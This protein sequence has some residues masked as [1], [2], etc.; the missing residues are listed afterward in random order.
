M[1]KKTLRLLIFFV[2]AGCGSPVTFDQPQPPKTREIHRF[3]RQLFGKYTSFD[4]KSTIIIN[5]KFILK[6]YDYDLMTSKDSLDK[7]YK[8]KGDTL[9]F[10]EG[11][12][13][14]L[15]KTIHD[16]IIQHVYSKETLFSFDSSTV[17]KK[18]KG[19]Y[20]LNYLWDKDKWIV[21]KMTLVKGILTLSDINTREEVTILNE[22]TETPA[23]TISYDFE[24]SKKQFK[25]FLKLG[26][27]RDTDFFIKMK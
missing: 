18:F 25:Q 10:R 17:L 8:I 26:G 7:S 11:D 19:N 4:S 13:Y 24:V 23:D 12:N 14:E 20:F 22:I 15:I 1:T 3:P 21:K 27:F 9:Y 2:I 5:E 16:S 6:I